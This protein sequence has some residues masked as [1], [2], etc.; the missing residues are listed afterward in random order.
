MQRSRSKAVRL[1]GSHLITT[2]AT[3]AA[4]LL[5]VGLGSQILP[6]A[7][8]GI[9]LPNASGGSLRLAFLL[10]IAIILF[11]WRRSKDLK[12][13]LDAYERAERAAHRNANTDHTTGL[14]NRRELLRSLADLLETRTPGVLLL[15]DLDHFK[16][17]NDLHGHLVG[18]QL[19]KAA[20]DSIRD[21]AP[22]AACCARIGGDE[23]AILLGDSSPAEAEALAER[24]L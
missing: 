5:F 10:N 3:M 17:V 18:D 23:F 4:I 16:R 8:A 22:A 6:F 9:E 20:A 21:A 24:L 12:V 15:L 2:C 14:A 7:L 19:L 13:A 1:A 11:G